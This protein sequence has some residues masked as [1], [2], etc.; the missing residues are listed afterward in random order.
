MDQEKIGKFIAKVRKERKLTQKELS[1]KLGITDR[2]ISKWENGKSM[3]DLALLKP[4]CDI[5]EI[6]INELLSGENIKTGKEKEKLE[7]NIVNAINYNKKR[8]NIYEIMFQ[9]FIIILG[10]FIFIMTMSIYNGHI[11][12]FLWYS[13]LGTYILIIIF[14]Y[15][16]NKIII[17]N[18]SRKYIIISVISFFCLY[19]IYLGIIDFS[20]VKNNNAEPNIFVVSGSVDK[21][22]FSYDTWFY[23]LYI[24][25]N[26]KSNEYKKLVFDIN[27][28]ADY[29]FKKMEKYCNK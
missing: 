5:L 26:N 25:N 3:P 7:E 11:S 29:N 17:N 18:K 22:N 21:D 1:E 14:S 10:I 15:F 16:L 4:L 13:V 6:T 20:N 28:D 2:A 24:C 27:H 9:S 19:F 8:K 23:D 12:S